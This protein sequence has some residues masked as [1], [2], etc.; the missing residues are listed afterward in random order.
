VALCFVA[1]GSSPPY[2]LRIRSP[3]GALV[4][5][6]LLREL[7]TGLPQAEPPIEFVVSNSGA[8]AIELKEIRGPQWCKATLQVTKT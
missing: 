4:I 8:Y 6:R 5:D 7:P 3:N 1:D 2:S